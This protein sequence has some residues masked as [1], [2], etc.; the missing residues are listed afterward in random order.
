M[1]TETISTIL[2]PIRMQIL[3]AVMFHKQATPKMIAEQLP[4]VPIASL[5]RHLNKM[6]EENVLEIVSEQKVRGAMEKTVK[7]REN[8]LQTM[9][10]RAEELKKA[11]VLE[12]F[13][14]FSVAQMMDM[15]AYVGEDE[16][17][18]EKN[19]LSFRSYI[20]N[21][22]DEEVLS[23]IREVQAIINKYGP[24]TSNDQNRPHKFSFALIPERLEKK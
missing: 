2:N 23:F 22:S 19:H 4:G 5:Y 21:L 10:L 15:T 24:A 18:I 8:P 13:Y 3:K 1:N 20:L 17:A 7:V 16:V 14:S 9:T 6:I 11:D 12:L